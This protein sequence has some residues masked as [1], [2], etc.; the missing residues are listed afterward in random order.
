MWLAFLLFR[1]VP[2]C[3]LV[4][5]FFWSGS[6]W[7]G[8]QGH[9]PL[10]RRVKRAMPARPGPAHVPP[11]QPCFVPCPAMPCHFLIVSCRPVYFIMAGLGLC[12]WSS[13]LYIR[14]NLPQFT[15]K[16]LPQKKKERGERENCYLQRQ[17]KFIIDCK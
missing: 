16:N 6:V 8:S 12:S 1:L 3:N 5:S 9:I 4:Q 13:F 17:K 14:I 15:Q 7:F 10:A 11:C 2:V